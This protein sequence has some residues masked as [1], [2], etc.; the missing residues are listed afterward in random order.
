MK[1]AGLELY[2]QRKMLADDKDQALQS[3]GVYAGFAAAQSDPGVRSFLESVAIKTHDR[4]VLNGNRLVSVETSLRM[5]G[6]ARRDGC[7]P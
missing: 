3:A 5:V 6:N 1:I 4:A 7:A 2:E